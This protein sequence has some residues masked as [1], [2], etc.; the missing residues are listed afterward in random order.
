MGRFVLIALMTVSFS[1]S[2]LSLRIENSD[3][4][5]HTIQYK[6]NGSS[7]SKTISA[8]RTG[9]YTL[10]STATS[11]TITGGS[12]AFPSKAIASGEKYKIKNAK[13]SKQ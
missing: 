12:V 6:C 11:C 1:A 2:A 3:S 10:H 4:K 7:F 8:S 9:T 13:A 5:A